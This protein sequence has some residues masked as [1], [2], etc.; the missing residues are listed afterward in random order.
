LLHID[1]CAISSASPNME[2]GSN[3][4]KGLVIL[5]HSIVI[6]IMPVYRDIKEAQLTAQ[7]TAMSARTSASTCKH[8]II[9]TA[10]INLYQ[11]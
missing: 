2:P 7:M 1:P 3:M 10:H 9:A 4:L 6:S 5:V 11:K 8:S